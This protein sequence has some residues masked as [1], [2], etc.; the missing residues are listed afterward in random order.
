MS[1]F[2]DAAA[3]IED[4]LGVPFVYFDGEALTELQGVFSTAYQRVEGNV[5]PAVA[6]SRPNLMIRR[7]VIGEPKKGDQLFEGQMADFDGEFTYEVA[8]HRADEERTGYILVLK[9]V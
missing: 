2:D 7:A 5:G 6:S 4:G 1:D 8:S 3:E 9:R